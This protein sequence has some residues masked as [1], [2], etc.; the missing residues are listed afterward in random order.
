MRVRR[1]TESGLQRFRD[2]IEQSPNRAVPDELVRDRKYSTEVANGPDVAEMKFQNRYEFGCYLV[3]QLAAHK[4]RSF[5]YD[6]GLWSWLALFYFDQI[7]PLRQGVRNPSR[8]NYYIFEPHEWTRYYHH[9]VRTPY[10]LVSIHGKAA[11]VLLTQPTDQSGEIIE[12]FASR[13]EIVTNASLIAAVRKLYLDVSD[14]EPRLKRG[15]AG[16]LSKGTF[17]RFAEV[18]PQFELTYDF[19]AM[20]PDEIL[21]ILP[22]EFDRFKE[23]R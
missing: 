11:Q 8:T 14:G 12:Q 9:M 16:R 21:D 23:T 7:C 5:Q 19:R 10:L 22:S 2:F 3:D 1:L 13:Q 17:R 6:V 18:L 15:S 20:S 4:E